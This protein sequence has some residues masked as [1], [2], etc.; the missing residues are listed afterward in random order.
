MQHPLGTCSCQSLFESS[1]ANDAPVVGAW[2]M[3]QDQPE[4]LADALAQARA[5]VAQ[6]KVAREDAEHAMGPL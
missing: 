1:T 3:N 6:G 2:G 5:L 4:R